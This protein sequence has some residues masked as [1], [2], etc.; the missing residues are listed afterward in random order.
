[1]FQVNL[2]NAKLSSDQVQS[3]FWRMCAG[4]NL[5]LVSINN[6]VGLFINDVTPKSGFNVYKMEMKIFQQNSWFTKIYHF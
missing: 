1:M 2:F 4:T 3:L 5:N 6:N